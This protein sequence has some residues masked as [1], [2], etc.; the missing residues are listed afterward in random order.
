MDQPGVAGPRRVGVGTDPAGR[1]RTHVVD[2]HVG[3]VDEGIEH[4]PRLGHAKVEGDA[5]LV[6]GHGEEERAELGPVGADAAH[7]VARRRLDLDHVGA[8]VAQQQRGVRSGEDGGEVDDT[9]AVERSLH[10]ADHGTARPGRPP[11][12]SK[13]EDGGLCGWLVQCAAGSGV[14]CGL[15]RSMDGSSCSEPFS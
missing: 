5:A 2:E 7:D 1:L 9:D 4:R 11:R 12:A 13:A 3:P 14:S 15:G 10:G 8:Q 6:A